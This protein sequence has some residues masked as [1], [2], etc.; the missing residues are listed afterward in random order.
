M[1]PMHVRL[2]RKTQTIFLLCEPADKC[3]KLKLRVAELSGLPAAN[4]KLFKSS[5]NG[6]LEVE[7]ANE[8]LLADHAIR[9]DDIVYFA[10]GEEAVDTTA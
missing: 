1:P 7:M 3:V 9:D 4:L 5:L 8:S 2:R 6:G 10:V